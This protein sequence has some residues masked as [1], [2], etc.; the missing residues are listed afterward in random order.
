M[1]NEYRKTFSGKTE[2]EARASL[3]RWCKKHNREVPAVTV[4]VKTWCVEV[5]FV[6][7]TK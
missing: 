5:S 3:E 7:T 2:E 4:K 1:T 6:D